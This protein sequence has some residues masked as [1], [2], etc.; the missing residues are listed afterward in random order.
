M[1]MKK[2]AIMNNKG[3]VGKT[4]TAINLADVLAHDFGDRVILVDCDGQANLTHFYLPAIDCCE[5]PTTADV[6]RGEDEREWPEDL[7]DL[8][9]NLR[10]LPGSSGLYDLDLSAVRDGVSA[11]ERLRAFAQAAEA[12]GGAEWM[13]FDCPPGYTVASVAALLAADEV[14]VPVCADKFSLDGVYSVAEQAGKLAAVKPGLRVRAL[15]TQVRSGAVVT[16]AEKALAHMRVPVFET[17]IRRSENVAESTLT[18]SPLREYS[19]RSSAGR[20]YRRLAAELVR[21]REV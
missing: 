15:L 3:G 21:A 5:V 14:L 1:K 16:E 20:D 6:L 12:D 11:P 7:L 17:R 13:L 2:I 10:L 4:V 19:P 9:E 8:C 18:M